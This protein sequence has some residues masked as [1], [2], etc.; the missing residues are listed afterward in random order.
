MKKLITLVLVLALVLTSVSALAY[1]PDGATT[2]TTNATTASGAQIIVN[3]DAMA[4]ETADAIVATAPAVELGNAVV[5][6]G[7]IA[8]TQDNS[9]RINGEELT[10]DIEITVEKNSDD[11][12]KG[13]EEGTLKVGY[14]NE[15]GETVW[16][17]VEFAIDPVT[18]NLIIILPPRIARSA[19][20]YGIVYRFE[21]PIPTQPQG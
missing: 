3:A 13:D 6:E 17:V 12:F 7:K 9:T 21:A 20:R 2:A 14:I 1:S 15:N 11:T 5:A 16:E 18:G 8:L 19:A 10:K 4:D